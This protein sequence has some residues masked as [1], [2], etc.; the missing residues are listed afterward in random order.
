MQAVKLRGGLGKPQRLTVRFTSDASPG[1]AVDALVLT[2]EGG[3]A[4]DPALMAVSYEAQ[5]RT[6]TW[7]FPG[8]ERG[9]LPEGRYALT[10]RAARVTTLLGQHLDGNADQPGPDDYVPEKALVSRRP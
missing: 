5:T 2:P 4:I 6:A 10:L 7:T 8:L 3:T 1:P 9:R